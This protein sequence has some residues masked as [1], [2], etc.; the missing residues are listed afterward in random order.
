MSEAG[1]KAPGAMAAI[2]GLP[3]Q[4]IEALCNEAASAGPV[5]AANFNSNEQTVISGSKEGVAKASEIAKA[6]GAKRVMELPVSGA[7]HSPL[8]QPAAAALRPL[9]EAA[10]FADA[11][12]PL[13][14]NVDA[15]PRTSG[16]EIRRTL[17]RQI[18]SPVQWEASVRRML[19]EGVDRFIEVGPGKVL[20]G[21]IRRVRP[22]AR[23][24]GAGTLEQ[25]G[26]L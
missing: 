24:D 17:A 10:P 6:K 7:F 25:I 23:V 9:L 26:S 15:T 21:L 13:V 18:V 1:S 11:K 3:P 20:A 12:A 22:E 5:Q 16:A 4:E 14:S 8:M 2:I 19:A